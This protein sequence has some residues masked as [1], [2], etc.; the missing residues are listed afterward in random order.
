MAS[1]LLE[2]PCI[3]LPKG[4]K[5]WHLLLNV[6]AN[7]ISN[8]R[9]LMKIQPQ[10][11]NYWKHDAA[12]ISNMRFG[13]KVNQ[14]KKKK[15]SEKKKE[16][17]NLHELWCD[18][19]RRSSCL[20]GEQCSKNSFLP[21]GEHVGHFSHTRLLI[22]FLLPRKKKWQ[23]LNGQRKPD[24]YK[25][26]GHWR[27]L[28]FEKFICVIYKIANYQGHLP[29]AVFISLLRAMLP[30]FNS[31]SCLTTVAKHLQDGKQRT[32]F[33][34]F[35]DCSRDLPL[36]FVKRIPDS[37]CSNRQ[38]NLMHSRTKMNI[39][40]ST[41]Q[42]ISGTK[43]LSWWERFPIK[44]VF[45]FAGSL[46]VMKNSCISARF[47]IFF[48]VSTTCGKPSTMQTHSYTKQLQCI[49][50]G[51]CPH[52][53]SQKAKKDI[54]GRKELTNNKNAHIWLTMSN[55]KTD[56]SSPKTCFSGH[57]R[58]SAETEHHHWRRTAL[59]YPSEMMYG[60]SMVQWLIFTP[61]T[62]PLVFG[63]VLSFGG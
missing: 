43:S 59:F 3:H 21:H 27:I 45:A 60:S 10:K 25:F 39:I 13:Q 33:S 11:R 7:K 14:K 9:I 31:F 54:I 49:K 62:S 4:P 37:T 47:V 30:F 58:S 57:L 34:L 41:S 36:Q 38:Q 50:Q 44:I 12:C 8:T 17:E 28:S 16:E 40:D 48:T 32:A 26:H 5:T 23:Q 24:V 22:N 2:S 20:F 51:H 18:C 46:R 1:L 29:P 63:S 56:S 55:E 42:N 52:N 19:W 6:K 35:R 53:A 61:I 15:K